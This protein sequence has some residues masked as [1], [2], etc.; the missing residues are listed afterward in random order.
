[1]RVA[2]IL[3][4]LLIGSLAAPAQQAAAAPK[5]PAAK[6]RA[7]KALSLRATYDAMPEPERRALQS[8]LLWS[9]DY[10]GMTTGEFDD[11]SIAAVKAFQ[12]RNKFKQTGILN[13]HE[14]ALRAA[15][16][17]ARAMPRSPGSSSGSGTG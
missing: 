17:K 14:R 8:D 1:M 3:A 10:Y 13:P 5:K 2:V 7:V 6:S 9:G 12:E 15:A 4:A 11:R 16:A